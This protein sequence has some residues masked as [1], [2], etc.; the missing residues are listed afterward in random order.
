[1][2]YSKT[3]KPAHAFW[4]R[5]E[6]LSDIDPEICDHLYQVGTSDL[7][8][9]PSNDDLIDAF[10]L[11]LTAQGELAT[12]PENPEEDEQGLSMEIVYRAQSS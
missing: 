7:G 10:A 11:A 4:E 1:M 8:G 9:S 6:T 2:K 12:L 3:S 5:V